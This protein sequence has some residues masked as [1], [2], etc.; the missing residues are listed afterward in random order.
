MRLNERSES[1]CV[2]KREAAAAALDNAVPLPLQR[3][4]HHLVHSSRGEEN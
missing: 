2:N 1:F 3:S 4:L